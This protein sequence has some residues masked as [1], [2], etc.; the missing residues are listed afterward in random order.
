[1]SRDSTAKPPADA[2]VEP[3]SLTAVPDPE[4]ER[5][6][7]PG[8]EGT[9]ASAPSSATPEREPEIPHEKLDPDAL[10][11]IYR[12]RQFGHQ[13]YL[14]GGC[15]R[16]L[17]LGGKPKD[18]DV[19]TSAHPGDVRATFRNCRLIGRRFRLAHVYFKGGKII[20]VSTF[21][22]NPTEV[23]LPGEPD[24]PSVPAEASNASA[25]DAPDAPDAP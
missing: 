25:P 5:A 19:A 10:K 17:L 23:G 14:V 15:V 2:P 24:E 21:R 18:F 4:V 22:A 3:G 9:D 12:L 8:G 1:M 16:D 20:E 7:P 13:V 6:A 11:V